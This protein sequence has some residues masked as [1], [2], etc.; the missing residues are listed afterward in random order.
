MKIAALDVSKNRIGIAITGTC[1]TFVDMMTVLDRKKPCFN[2]K[3]K[4]FFKENS[5]IKVYIGIVYHNKV[6]NL[7]IKQFAHNWRDILS[8]FEFVHEGRTTALANRL[9]NHYDDIDAVSARLILLS[10]LL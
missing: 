2:K 1:G 6:Q 5:P 8:P 3:F 4:L 10:K 7:F 9:L